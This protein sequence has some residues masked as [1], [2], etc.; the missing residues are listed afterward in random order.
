MTDWL[1]LEMNSCSHFIWPAVPEEQSQ[2]QLQVNRKNPNTINPISFWIEFE[3]IS[4]LPLEVYAAD[5]NIANH[6]FAINK[7]KPECSV[8]YYADDN[9][10]DYT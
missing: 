8:L 6:N 3:E 7:R 4:S 5:E 9:R 10:F 1:A 2:R